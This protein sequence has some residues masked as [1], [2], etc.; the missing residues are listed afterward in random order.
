MQA[1]AYQGEETAHCARIEDAKRAVAKAMSE[2][3]T[4]RGS[5]ASVNKAN[6][7]L[8][9]AWHLQRE[10]SGGRVPQDR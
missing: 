9:N 6:A 4:G 1:M 7:D 2:H 8:A 10:W 3:S 5:L